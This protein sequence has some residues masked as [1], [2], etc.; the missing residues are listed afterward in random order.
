MQDRLLKRRLKDQGIIRPDYLGDIR[1][2]YV[3]P[4]IMDRQYASRYYR[5]NHHPIWFL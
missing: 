3:N 4:K 5:C 1:Y 2:Q